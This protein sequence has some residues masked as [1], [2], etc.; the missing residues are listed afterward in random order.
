[1]IFSHYKYFDDCIDEALQKEDDWYIHQRISYVRCKKLWIPYPFQNNISM[2]SKE[3][4]V[5]CVAGMIDAALDSRVSN[6]TPRNFDEW[7]LK[8]MGTG[9]ADL[10]MRPY[11][12][13]VW[14]F[15]TTKVR[16]SAPP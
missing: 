15:P 4:Q 13:K 9:I 2:L 11:N 10:F 14:A 8:T 3:D 12:F 5:E 6:A 16:L 7:I 1:V